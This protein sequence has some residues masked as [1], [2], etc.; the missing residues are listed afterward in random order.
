MTSVLYVEDEEDDVY[1]MRQSFRQAGLE[2]CLRVAVNGQE[3]MDYLSGR[4]RFGNRVEYP[5]P[6]VVLLDLNLPILPGF[7]VLKWIREQAQ[8]RELPVIIFSSSSRRED[9][10]K[11]EEFGATDYLEKPGSGLEFSTVVEAL[12]K[13]WLKQANVD[14][15]AGGA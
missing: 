10:L 6:A 1:F 15:V 5:I 9:R 4:G 12:V 8:F 14:V 3:A 13:R 11:A 7:H 2:R